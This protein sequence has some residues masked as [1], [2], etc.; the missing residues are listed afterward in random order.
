M[1]S[2]PSSRSPTFESRVLAT[3]NLGSD[4]EEH[5]LQRVAM[6]DARVVER[7]E[8]PH[9]IVLDGDK[10]LDRGTHRTILPRH[11]RRAGG[12]NKGNVC[13]EESQTLDLPGQARSLEP[14]FEQLLVRLGDHAPSFGM[15]PIEGDVVGLFGKKCSVGLSVPAAPSCDELREQG[16]ESRGIG[17]PL[18]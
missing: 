11:Q 2:R 10:G 7:G 1:L 18:T 17:T 12:M 8:A 3:E 9:T 5:P 14:G 6:D 15:R 16:P 13:A 4:S